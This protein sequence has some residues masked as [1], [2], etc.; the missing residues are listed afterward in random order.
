MKFQSRQWNFKTGKALKKK[1]RPNKNLRFLLD[2][3]KPRKEIQD[4]EKYIN[5]RTIQ[6][7]FTLLLNSVMKSGKN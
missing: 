3:S 1:V 5:V 6:I 7:P 2:N 4:Q